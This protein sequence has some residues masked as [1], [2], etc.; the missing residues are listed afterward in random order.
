MLTPMV[1]CACDFETGV[2]CDYHKAEM[3]TRL[4]GIVPGEIKYCS[5]GNLLTRDCSLCNAAFAQLSEVQ[6]QNV[7]S[8]KPVPYVSD[9]G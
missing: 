4:K 3:L 9:Q 7:L 5:H 6:K 8:G 1:G 2:M